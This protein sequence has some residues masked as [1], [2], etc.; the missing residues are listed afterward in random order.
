MFSE[1]HRGTCTV[2]ADPMKF[3][4]KVLEFA[5]ERLSKRLKFPD[6]LESVYADT[7][8]LALYYEDS[9]DAIV[10]FEPDCGENFIDMYFDDC[11]LVHGGE[12]LMGVDDD[13]RIYYGIEPD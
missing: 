9:I 4:G 8:R 6:T 11:N 3:A 13:G 10:V 2:Y 7:A 12:F 5:K 1:D